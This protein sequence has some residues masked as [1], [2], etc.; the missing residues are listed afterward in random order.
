[1]KTKPQEAASDTQS[2]KSG[3]TSATDTKK[4]G[5]ITDTKPQKQPAPGLKPKTAT[6]EPVKKAEDN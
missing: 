4:T 2:Q 3:D 6:K 5:K 1:V